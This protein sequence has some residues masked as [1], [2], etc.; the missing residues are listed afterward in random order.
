MIKKIKKKNMSKF[1][2]LLMEEYSLIAPVKKGNSFAFEAISSSDDL[3][4]EYDTTILPPKKVFLPPEEKI[5]EFSDDEA[6]PPEPKE[7][8]MMLFGVHPCDLNGILLMDMVEYEE[9]EDPYYTKRRENTTIVAL[10]CKEACEYCFCESMG[11][12]KAEKGFDLL[13][14]DIGKSYFVETGS[15]KGEEILRRSNGF[16]KDASEKDKKEKEREFTRKVEVGDLPNALRSKFEDE[17]WEELGDICLGCGACSFV[18]PTCY[19]YSVKD[20][21]DLSLK[22]GERTRFWDSCLLVDFSRVAGGLNF[23]GKRSARIQQ[24]IYHKDLYFVE[25]YGTSACVGCGRCIRCCP[26]EI[27]ITDIIN[28]VVS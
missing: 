11:S 3:V 6:R 5:L 13:L 1:V 2:D 9:Y 10:N 4:L 19:C 17:I 7:E 27:D 23:R 21:V 22:S 28:R 20:I 14:T 16:F 18:C 15:D 8:K 24:R 25:K 26:A 12:E